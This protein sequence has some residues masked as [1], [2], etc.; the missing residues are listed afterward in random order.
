MIAPPQPVSRT[1]TRSARLV[2]PPEAMIVPES[3]RH[4]S[5]V[6][7]EVRAAQ[8][9]IAVD[10]GHLEG[11]DA[12]IGQAADGVDGVHASVRLGPAVT[13]GSAVTDVD[14]D[15]DPCGPV[16]R[17]QLAGERR[18]RQGRGPDDRPGRPAL[19][20]LGHGPGIAQAA[21]DLDPNT[22]PDCR[23]DGRDDRAMRRDAGP[24]GVEIDDVQPRRA[25][26]RELERGRDRIRVVCGLPVEVALGEP[27]HASPTQVDRRQDVEGPCVL[28]GDIVS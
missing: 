22:L 4:Q 2:M 27:D 19:D 21:R 7:R 17:H 20:D 18:G 13:D 5:F 23:G 25:R 16:Y 14:G 8:K 3:R 11:L 1:A 24:G 6:E 28:H 10:R 9:A 12:L 15:S 26:R